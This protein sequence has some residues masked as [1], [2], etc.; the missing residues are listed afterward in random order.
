MMSWR[1]EKMRINNSVL[2]ELKNNEAAIVYYIISSP[3]KAPSSTLKK[4]LDR[5]AKHLTKTHK[6][7]KERI[8]IGFRADEKYQTEV[9]IVPPDAFNDFFRSLSDQIIRN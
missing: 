5:I 1:D 9:Y 4:R 8:K 6:I 3:E 2:V 7:A